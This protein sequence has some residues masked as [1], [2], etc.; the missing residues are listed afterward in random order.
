MRITFL[1]ATGEVTGSQHLLETRDRRILLDC[2]MFQGRRDESRARNERLLCDPQ[3]LDAVILSH[4]HIDH[5]GN[6][7]TLCRAGFHGAVF[8]TEAT[9]DVAQVMLED[10]A[11]IQEEDARYLNKRSPAGAPTIAPLYRREDVN[12]AVRLFE[13]L[14]YD[15]W[16]E[17][18]RDVRLKFSDA[19]HVL[20]SAITELE[21]EDRGERRRLVFTGDLG[22]RGLPLLRDP[23]TVSGCDILITESTYGDR[24]HKPIHKT[25]DELLRVVREAS[26]VEGR[27]IIPA[28]SLGRTQQLVYFLNELHDEQRLPAIPVFVDSPLSR[29]LTSV[30]RHHLQ[31]A[32]ANAHNVLLSDSDPLDRPNIT[33]V[34]TRQESQALNH[35]KGPFVVISASGMCESGRV[36]HHLMHAVEDAKNTIVIVGYQG[37]HTLGRR[38]AERQPRL[39]ILDQ[40]FEL[41]ANVEVLSGLSAHAD[42]EDFKW[43]FERLAAEGGVGQAFVVHGEQRA[44]TSLAGL[45]RDECDEPPIIPHWGQA[46][47]V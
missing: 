12:A 47:D 36:L 7:P 28:F 46:F 1:G 11:G 13:P 45:L 16:H 9:A 18:A 43:W 38:I 23:Q 22:R 15:T 24:C 35:R 34:A 27:I 19:G 44:A 41:R 40:H 31:I 33:Y 17:L 14:P 25:K 4:G 39:R 5:C 21:V 10:S 2:G 26:A 42:A 32:D 30:Y 3:E 29:R 8:C 37:Q 20:G 6:L